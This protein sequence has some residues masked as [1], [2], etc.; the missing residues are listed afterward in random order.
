MVALLRIEESAR[1]GLGPRNGPSGRRTLQSD[2]LLLRAHRLPLVVVLAA[3]VLLE[4]PLV[5]LL[6]RASRLELRGREA[7]I[8]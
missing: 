7:P 6:L 3:C 1:N 4:C 8:D 2:Q 5:I